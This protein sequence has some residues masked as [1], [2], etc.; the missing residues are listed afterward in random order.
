M[1]IHQLKEYVEVWNCEG[2]KPF[3]LKN[4]I[5]R[6]LYKFKIPYKTIFGGMCGTGLLNYDEEAIKEILKKSKGQIVI[7]DFQ[8]RDIL[9]KYGFK[10]Y[11]DWTFV[12]DI[13]NIEDLW[14]KID[15]KNRNDIRYAEKSKVLFEEVES[16]EELN[17]LYFLF[18]EQAKRWNFRI[19]SK[20]YFENVWNNM[21]KNN[22]AKFF[23]AKYQKEI[24]SITQLFMFRDEIS[25][26][27]WGNSEKANKIRG[28]NN[29][30]IWK[31]IEWSN[32][33]NYKKFNMWGADP[34]QEGIFKFKESFGGLLVKVN[35]YEKAWWPYDIA[36][37]LSA[38]Q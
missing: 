3:I 15:K 12:I 27:I 4:A 26:P 8:E 24:V 33:N 34:K 16:I 35:R 21:V 22:M 20:D 1:N 11:G 14:K 36:K 18:R 7:Y 37:K 17:K 31:I 30:L 29:L 9:E 25:M 5:G 19:P 10:K 23:V 38:K 13:S 32:K 6:V 2:Y 28:A